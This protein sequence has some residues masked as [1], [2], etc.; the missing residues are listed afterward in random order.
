MFAF[1]SPIHTEPHWLWTLLFNALHIAGN[2]VC[3]FVSVHTR[4]K[5]CAFGNKDVNEGWTLLLGK[6]KIGCPVHIGANLLWTF[7]VFNPPSHQNATHVFTPCRSNLVQSP[8]KFHSSRWNGSKNIHKIQLSKSTKANE[9]HIATRYDVNWTFFIKR[10]T[11]NPKSHFTFGVWPQ[12]VSEIWT[13]ESKVMMHTNCSRNEQRM[14]RILTKW[15]NNDG[16][17][18]TKRLR[19]GCGVNNWTVFIQDKL[20]CEFH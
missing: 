6:H 4:I 2:R 16:R 3:F 9:I 17:F 1:K 20:V 15:T 8:T 19:T 5:G 13:I 11:N 12:V 7:A 10:A 18:H 14:R